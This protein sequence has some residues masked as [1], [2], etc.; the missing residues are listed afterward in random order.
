MYYL[1]DCMFV[2]VVRVKPTMLILDSRSNPSKIL[3]HYRNV[4]KTI[5]E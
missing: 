4:A 1:F 2:V 5:V 3:L